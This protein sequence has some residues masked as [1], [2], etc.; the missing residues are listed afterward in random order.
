VEAYEAGGV[1]IDS[2]GKQLSHLDLNE[3]DNPDVLKWTGQVGI[4]AAKTLARP[5]LAVDHMSKGANGRWPRG[6]G[7]K[8]AAADL[9]WNVEKVRDFS[10]DE[11]GTIKL[12]HHGWNRPGRMP[13]ELFFDTGGQGEGGK[14]ALTETGAPPA[15]D[16]YRPGDPKRQQAEADARWLAEKG[17]VTTGEAMSFMRCSDKTARNRLAQAGATSAG[18]GKWRAAERPAI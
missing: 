16:H 5:V 2:I 12:Q 4:P 6:A 7:E 17:V 11:V 15:E 18:H 13:A 8:M 9:A 10:V 14:W 1:V 3:Y